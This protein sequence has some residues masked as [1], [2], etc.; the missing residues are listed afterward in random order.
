MLD[1]DTKALDAVYSDNI[2]MQRIEKLSMIAAVVRN[3][4]ELT[5]HTGDRV[6][7]PDPKNAAMLDQAEPTTLIENLDQKLIELD[8][9]AKW[10]LEEAER[11]SRI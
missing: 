1:S 10:A 7:G 6:F 8:T 4:A 9:A 2:L 3:A 11:L 5:M